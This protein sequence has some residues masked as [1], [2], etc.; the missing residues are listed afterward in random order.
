MKIVAL[1]DTHRQHNKITVPDGD[2]LIFTGD[3]EITTIYSF[4]E[5]ID[6]FTSHPHKYKLFIAGNHDFL[7]EGRGRGMV[8]HQA[9]VGFNPNKD[10]DLGCYYLQDGYVVI[11]GV[12]FYGTPWTPSFNDWAFMK[13]E[14]E[15]AHVYSN[16]TKDVD[17]LITHGPPQGKYDMNRD[18]ESCGSVSL[19]KK[20]KSLKFKHHF[21][22]HIHPH[23]P[24]H[25]NSK[26]YHN[27]SVLN[28]D[29]DVAWEPKIINV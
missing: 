23:T 5:W 28:E 6:W 4:H 20:I 8:L 12:K 21:F 13:S 16:I 9:G 10:I 11:D 26:R 7:Y 3:A 15:L 17:I 14:R 25:L 24:Y 1:G 27:V 19:R 2:V 29:Y 22:G 18:D